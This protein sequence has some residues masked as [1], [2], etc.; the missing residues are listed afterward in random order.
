MIKLWG[1]AVDWIS[2]FCLCD[3]GQIVKLL[4]LLSSHLENGDNN[5]YLMGLLRELN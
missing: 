4:K 5:I 3:L 1:S 2:T